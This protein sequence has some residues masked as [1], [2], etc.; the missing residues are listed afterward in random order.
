[1]EERGGAGST[2]EKNTVSFM[3]CA[4]SCVMRSADTAPT[5]ICTGKRA[6]SSAPS[7]RATNSSS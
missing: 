3:A 1:M 2:G 6:V 5:L 7:A 4:G